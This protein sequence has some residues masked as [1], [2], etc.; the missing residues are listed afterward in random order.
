MASQER[1][2]T[3]EH[4]A[5][6]LYAAA[7]AFIRLYQF[8][9]RDQ[10]LKYGLTVVQAYALDILVA[11]G[12]QGLTALA[13]AIRL[14]KST[15]S[16]VVSGMARNGLVTWT[17]PPQDRR[18]KQIVASAEGRQRYARLRHAIVGANARLLASY[19]RPARRAA[20]DILRQL[21]DRA[22]GAAD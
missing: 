10:A 12:G 3:L 18:A 16:R 15:M 6:A 7:T 11:T 9:D 22:G 1:R 2:S 13:D 21:T 8:R 19:P 20:I 4:D 14:D 5:A 17:R